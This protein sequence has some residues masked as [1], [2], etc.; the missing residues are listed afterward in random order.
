M[1]LE[2]LLLPCYI[3]PD[4]TVM[5]DWA[6]KIN[7][8]YLSTMLHSKLFHL[9]ITLLVLVL[10]VSKEMRIKICAN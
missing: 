7:Y 10:C 5:V 2:F 6:L 1:Y 3:G 4:I 8:Q 9:F